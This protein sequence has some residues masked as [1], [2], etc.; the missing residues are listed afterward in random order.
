M[1]GSQTSYEKEICDHIVEIRTKLRTRQLLPRERQEEMARLQRYYDELRHEANEHS[2]APQR[3][4]DN[5]DY[6][7]RCEKKK[8]M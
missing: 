5:L 3:L 1:L 6:I 7:E 4:K 2:N 8:G